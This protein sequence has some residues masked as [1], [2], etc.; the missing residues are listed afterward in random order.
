[1]ACQKFTPSVVCDR[2]HW[3]MQATVQ[4]LA[5]LIKTAGSDPA[6]RP[7]RVRGGGSKDFYGE[8]LQGTVLDTGA[9]NQVVAYEPTE[10]VITA[11]AGLRLRDLEAL[12]ATH[13]QCLPCDPPHF[14]PDATIGGAVAAA[15]SGPA[16]ASVGAMK[17]FVLGIKMLNAAGELLTFGGQ[18]MKNVAGY[19]ISR[20]MAGS[21]GTLGV[22]TEVS[23]K[24]LPVA[25]AEANLKFNCGQAQALSLI[26][27]WGGQPLPLNASVW[28]RD[29][30][31]RDSLVE[32]GRA[33]CRE[34]V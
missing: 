7:L 13:N 12:L 22:L 25:P 3:Q 14:G 20:L 26:N 30:S 17:D 8:P 34:R 16:R 24:V 18:V 1:M 27:T 5:D 28:K 33:S 21:M 4:A 9:L 11:G 29:K 31:G 19:D 6:R 10:L 2:Y 32:I 23:I 15:L